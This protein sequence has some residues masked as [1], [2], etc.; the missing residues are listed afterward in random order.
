LFFYILQQFRKLEEDNSFNVQDIKG[1]E[2]EVY[3]RL[4]PAGQGIGKIQVSHNGSIH[5]IDAVA[6][7]ESLATGDKVMIMEVLPGDVVVVER[8]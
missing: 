4:P 7:S 3:L 8:L 5:E 1:K 6:K 2:A